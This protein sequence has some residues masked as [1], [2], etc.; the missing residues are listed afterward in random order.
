MNTRVKTYF[1]VTEPIIDYYKEQGVLHT[2][3]SS[4]E[5]DTVFSEIEKIL[6]SEDVNN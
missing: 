5:V 4:Q 6:G 2:V 1:E 3:D